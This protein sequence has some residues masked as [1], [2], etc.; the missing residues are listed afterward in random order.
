M[1]VNF[2]GIH[3]SYMG[4]V[5]CGASPRNVLSKNPLHVAVM[6]IFCLC[7]ILSHMHS[8]WL[9]PSEIA[10]M[11]QLALKTVITQISWHFNGHCRGG[12]VYAFEK[13]S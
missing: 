4:K 13:C 6:R 9:R 5:K 8:I 10:N 7:S 11:P 12:N 3:L 2:A 1:H